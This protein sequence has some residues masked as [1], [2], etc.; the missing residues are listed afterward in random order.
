MEF[1]PVI[2]GTGAK[3]TA[4]ATLDTGPFPQVFVPFTATFPAVFPKVTVILFVF[5]PAV[6]TA[7]AGRVQTYPVAFTIG[8]TEY[9]LPELFPHTVVGPVIVPGAPGRGQSDVKKVM[10]F[11][12]DVPTLFTPF[13]LKWSVVRGVSPAMLAL[14]G[15]TVLP[16][17]FPGTPGTTV[18]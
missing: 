6:I 16:V 14:T 4:T 3:V 10:S 15:V 18:P 13:T 17:T 11:P 12:F 5:A 2:V 1:W 7:P 8:A 9:M